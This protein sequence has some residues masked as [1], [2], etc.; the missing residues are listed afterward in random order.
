M[1]H[2][3]PSVSRP[4]FVTPLDV[5]RGRS[6]VTLVH[7]VQGLSGGT[8]RMEVSPLTVLGPPGV[9]VCP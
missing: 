4:T 8:G 2:P 7:L 9:G 1:A 6:V 3:E 5:D